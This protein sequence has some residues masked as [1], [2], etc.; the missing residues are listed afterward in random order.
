M[1]ALGCRLNLALAGIAFRRDT[2][3]R[4]GVLFLEKEIQSV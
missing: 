1:R 4:V 2:R 3:E